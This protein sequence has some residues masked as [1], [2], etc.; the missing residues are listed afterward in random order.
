MVQRVVFA[1]AAVL[2]WRAVARVC[3]GALRSQKP[4]QAGALVGRKFF[5][6][7]SIAAAAV[8]AWIA[9]A[10][11]AFAAVDTS[12]AGIATVAAVGVI[13]VVD[14][15]CAVCSLRRVIAWARVAPAGRPDVSTL[16][17]WPGLTVGTAR[18][19]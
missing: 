4:L 18:K 7:S 8:D 15:F 14:L 5:V 19:P 11:R 16:T 9:V 13:V 2:A 10:R 6:L 1:R 17:A 3:L 12:P